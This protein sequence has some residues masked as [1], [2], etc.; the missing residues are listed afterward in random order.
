MKIE[1]F[2]IAFSE[3][4]KPFI[5][6]EKEWKPIDVKRE[7]E[8]RKHMYVASQA[9]GR[10]KEK[11]KSQ[12]FLFIFQNSEFFPERNIPKG[13]LTL[14]DL[15]VAGTSRAAYPKVG[16]AFEKKKSRTKMS[17]TSSR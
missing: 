16:G 12:F 9:L 1:K 10:K 8:S 5:P 14:A 6:S 3:S 2:W 11:E 15:F 13:P 17:A 7:L 4:D